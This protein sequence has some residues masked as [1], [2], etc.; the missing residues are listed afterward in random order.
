[1]TGLISK[2]K[3]NGGGKGAMR[4]GINGTEILESEAPNKFSFLSNKIK[5]YLNLKKLILKPSFHVNI[6]KK[7][8]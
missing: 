6:L 8:H 3:G 5:M 4:I 7:C 1:M 2:G